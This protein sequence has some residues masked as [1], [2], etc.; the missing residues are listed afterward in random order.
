[1]MCFRES[2]LSVSALQRQSGDTRLGGRGSSHQQEATLEMPPNEVAASAC[3][4]AMQ[5]GGTGAEN[6]HFPALRWEAG[7]G[8]APRLP[9]SEMNLS[10]RGKINLITCAL[11]LMA[12]TQTRVHKLTA[13][14]TFVS[15]V[16]SGSSQ[17]FQ[18]VGKCQ[19]GYFVLRQSQRARCG[20]QE[21]GQCSEPGCS[22]SPTT[23][24]QGLPGASPPKSPCPAPA[25]KN[26]A[27]ST[28]SGQLRT[29]F[30]PQYSLVVMTRLDRLG[31]EK[32]NCSC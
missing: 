4:A 20:K 14:I 6:P 25:P 24:Q 18:Q 8:A 27:T 13:G 16:C 5:P 26:P 28:A 32:K 22:A 1:M 11:S 30:P 17:A 23:S 15:V 2:P 21:A 3:R 12:T 7:S 9:D 29:Y 19:C 10:V 31:A